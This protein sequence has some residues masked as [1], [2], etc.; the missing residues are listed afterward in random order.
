MAG[1]LGADVAV[2]GVWERMNVWSIVGC[3]GIENMGLRTRLTV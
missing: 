2:E 3:G 1:G